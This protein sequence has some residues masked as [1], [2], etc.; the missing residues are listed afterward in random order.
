[1]Y[2][3]KLRLCKKTCRTPGSRR[4]SIVMIAHPRDQKEEGS[5]FRREISKGCRH[6]DNMPF[7]LGPLA[8]KKAWVTRC[9]IGH[10]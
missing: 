10:L 7:V 4:R 9:I 6:G 5:G 1:M 3:V 2:K 8:G